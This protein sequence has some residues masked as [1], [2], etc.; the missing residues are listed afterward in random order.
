LHQAI[1]TITL[2]EVR[3]S[4]GYELISVDL[5]RLV[6]V[7]EEDPDAWLVHGDAGGSFTMVQDA[8]AG[9]LAPNQ[10]WGSQHTEPAGRAE[11]FVPSRD[12]STFCPVDRDKIAFYALTPRI[13]TA[14]LPRGWKAEEMIAVTLSTDKRAP[15]DFHV[16]GDQIRVSANAQQPDEMRT[17]HR[18]FDRVRLPSPRSNRIGFAGVVRS[19][20]SVAFSL[21]RR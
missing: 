20:S 21:R 15:V 3:E 5:P 6:T 4:P 13:L 1:I 8:T 19:V 10:F 2:E 9:A 16:G 14:T 11:I 18:R 17:A 7:R 12:N